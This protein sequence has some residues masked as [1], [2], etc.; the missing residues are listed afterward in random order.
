MQSHPRKK[1]LQSILVPAASFKKKKKKGVKKLG[2]V[3]EW[4]WQ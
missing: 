2:Q 4:W 1:L 3:W